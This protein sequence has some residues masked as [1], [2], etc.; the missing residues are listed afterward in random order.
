MKHWM[1][2]FALVGAA[3]AVIGLCVPA[4]TAGAAVGGARSGVR[5]V[6]NNGTSPG[7]AGYVIT[8]A[9]ASA[10]GKVKITVPSITGCT[11]SSTVTSGIAIG[12]FVFTSTSASAAFVEAVCYSG[13]PAYAGVLVVNGVQTVITTFAPKPGATVTLK[14][15]ESATATKVKLTDVTTGKTQ[16]A[17]GTGGTNVDVFEGVDALD[18][19]STG[20]Q[21]PN[22]DFSTITCSG[23]KIDSVTVGAAGAS[24]INEQTSGGTLQILTG[25]LNAGGN[26][27]TETYEHA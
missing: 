20:A 27:W 24:G 11:P 13:A 9:P 14:V 23:G 1:T 7:A 8:T 17:S 10:N 2:R 19:S 21:L 25:A 12:A 22:P 26:G 16:S 15:S 3:A 5:L 4:S 6:F 18:N